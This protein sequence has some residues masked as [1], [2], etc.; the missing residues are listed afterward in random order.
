MHRTDGA[1]LSMFE[2]TVVIALYLSSGL[3]MSPNSPI[4]PSLLGVQ[5]FITAPCG[6]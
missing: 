6:K 1:W 2:N 5:R 3:R 4:W